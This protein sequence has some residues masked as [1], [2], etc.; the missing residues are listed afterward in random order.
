MAD[1]GRE[2]QAHL[3]DAIRARVRRHRGNYLACVL[4][5]LLMTVVGRA[6]KPAAAVSAAVNAML[7]EAGA[8]VRVHLVD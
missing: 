8:R 2:G 6:D 1:I 5:W 3:Q 7:L 4:G